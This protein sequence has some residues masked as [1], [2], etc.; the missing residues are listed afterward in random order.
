MLAKKSKLGQLQG[1]IMF[2][3]RCARCGH[4]EIFHQSIGDLIQFFETELWPDKEY[5]EEPLLYEYGVRT[6]EDFDKFI[7]NP[8]RGHK[9]PVIKCP[10]FTYKDRD[11]SQVVRAFAETPEAH[12]FLPNGLVT[13]IYKKIRQIDKEK[14]MEEKRRL[15][16]PYGSPVHVYLIYGGGRSYVAIGE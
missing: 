7:R 11:K 16:Q 9:I 4:Q 2:G 13:R 15:A 5:F 6:L 12:F 1:C 10:R 3:F 14:R 8:R